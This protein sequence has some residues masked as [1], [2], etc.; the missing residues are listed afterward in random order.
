M[1]D[2]TAPRS[3]TPRPSRAAALLSG[4]GALLVGGAVGF[5]VGRRSRPAAAT[6]TGEGDRPPAA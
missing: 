1:A 2:T 3:S 6:L 5:V 4:A